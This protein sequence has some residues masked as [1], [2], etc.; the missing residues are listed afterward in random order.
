MKPLTIDD[1]LYAYL[2][3]ETNYIGE[4][5]SSILRRLLGLTADTPPAAKPVAGNSNSDADGYGDWKTFLTELG[6]SGA[7]LAQHTT[8]RF[9]LTL[10]EVHRRDPEGFE[11]ILN[12]RGRTRLYFAKSA[13]EITR[14]S[15]SGDPR[16][17]PDSGYW[18]SCN[19]STEQKK[20]ILMKGLV[21]LGCNRIYAESAAA[22]L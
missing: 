14:S 1:E 20:R 10:A 15:P 18:V 8:G 6:S 3:S 17:I 19:A 7:F 11:G 9:L 21:T 13:E 4:D 2:A 5:A 22:R 12:C 16:R